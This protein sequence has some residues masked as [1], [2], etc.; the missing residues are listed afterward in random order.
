MNRKARV[1]RLIFLLLLL[2][3]VWSF[4]IWVIRPVRP[5]NVLILDKSVNDRS[6]QEHKSLNCILIQQKFS[7]PDGKLYRHR[8]DYMGFFPESQGGD[9]RIIDLD[10]VVV[11]KLDTLSSENRL[12]RVYQ[13]KSIPNLSYL[14]I[15]SLAEQLDVFYYTDGYG[16]YANEWFKNKSIPFGQAPRL[17]G[18][19]TEKELYLIEQM[20]KR[21]KLVI[22]EFNFYQD[23]TPEGIKRK[24]LEA[25]NVQTTGW[26]GSFVTSLDPLTNR[27]LPTFSNLQ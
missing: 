22:T 13:R 25:I 12:V 27:E 23:P 19:M 6:V 8:K 5:L 15:D 20:K 16:V 2:V 11:A 18:G 17:Y 26:V 14:Q 1:Y 7:K 9:F 24:A 3:P 21:H 10:S 4:L